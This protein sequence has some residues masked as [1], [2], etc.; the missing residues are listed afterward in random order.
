M[1]GPTSSGNDYR[2]GVERHSRAERFRVRQQTTRSGQRRSL[3]V[4]EAGPA[5]SHGQLCLLF[6][7]TLSSRCQIG[8]KFPDTLLSRYERALCRAHYE[9]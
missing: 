9:L 1:A 8:D 4:T 7:R 6:F 5:Q 2:H 3:N